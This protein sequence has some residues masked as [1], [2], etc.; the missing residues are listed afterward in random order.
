MDNSRTLDSLTKG[1]WVEENILTRE[2]LDDENLDIYSN[3][4]DEY[5]R[6]IVPLKKE[7]NHIDKNDLNNAV[8]VLDF[9]H[10]S[11]LFDKVNT[12]KYYKRVQNWKGLVTEIHSNSFKAKL[13]DLSHGGTNEIGEFDLE[14]VSPSDLNLLQKGSIFYWS[15]GRYMEN[16]QSVNRSDIRFQRLI[17]LDEDDIEDIKQSIEKK[18]SNLK[19]RII[20]NRQ[21]EDI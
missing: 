17:T 6:K 14:E 20:D 18:Y 5:Y 7:T 19:E 15:V 9:P 1:N 3:V 4:I 12:K 10:Y 21:A 16:G 11:K 2:E 13:F 8:P